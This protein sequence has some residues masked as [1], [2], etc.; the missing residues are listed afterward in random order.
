MNNLIELEL[1]VVLLLSIAALVA[2]LIRSVKLPYTVALVLVGLILSFF[3][4]FLGFTVSSDLIIAILVPP[5]L[6]EA[7]LHIKWHSLKTDLFLV[8]LLAVAGTM[9]GTLIVGSIIAPILRIPVEAALAFGALISATDPVAVIAFFRTLGVSKRLSILVEGESMFNDGVAIVLF[10]LAVGA[11]AVNSAATNSTIGLSDGLLQFFQVSF[12]GIGIGLLLGF[13]VSYVILKNVDD[14]LIETATTVAL[15]FGSF[16]VAEEFHFSGIL[17]VVAAGLMVGNIGTAN[18]S[19]TTQLTLENFWEFL[20]FAV[21]S[22]VFLLIGL[23]IEIAQLLPNIIPIIVAVLAVLLSRGIIVYVITGLHNRFAP[24]RHHLPELYRPVMYWGGL[25]GAISLALA[26]T[27]NGDLLGDRIA[28]ELRVMTF[29]VVLFTLLV[30]GTTIERLIR[31]LGLATRPKQQVELQ[32]RLGLVYAKRAGKQELD[33]L[34]DEG[35]LFRDIWE[36]MSAVYD[37]ELNDHKLALRE[38]LQTFAE[39]ELEMY[40][41]AREDVLMAERSALSDAARRGFISDE[42]QHDLI[43]EADDR[44][45]ALRLIQENRQIT[46]KGGANTMEEEE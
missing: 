15:A 9:I 20:A 1:G 45:A 21:N 2:I 26:L 11:T 37:I 16:V 4:N 13:V 34:H 24:A 8:I 28:A 18:T 42:V 43:R 35:I 7:T 29:G 33:R 27:L 25:R 32:R 22:L 44:M 31:R 30:Q 41:Q 36:A 40:L 14:H 23:E 5:L 6:F 10:N 12:G 17:A 38:H 3:P 46:P 39:L 19:P